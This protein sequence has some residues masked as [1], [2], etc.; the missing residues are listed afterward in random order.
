MK[1]GRPNEL[2]RDY[3]SKGE[4]FYIGA[5]II[6]MQGLYM[7]RGIIVMDLDE[8][9]WKENIPIDGKRYRDKKD[10]THDCFSFKD[11]KVESAL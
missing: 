5:Q 2:L 11:D 4:L 9:V 3:F 6:I 10:G 1:D 8:G 7:E